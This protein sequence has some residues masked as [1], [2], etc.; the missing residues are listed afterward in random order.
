MVSNKIIAFSIHNACM[1]TALFYFT[2]RQSIREAGLC[3]SN[4]EKIKALDAKIKLNPDNNCYP[5]TVLPKQDRFFSKHVALYEGEPPID[6]ESCATQFVQKLREVLPSLPS[7]PEKQ[8]INAIVCL[9]TLP[10]RSGSLSHAF[11]IS[12]STK[13]NKIKSFLAEL[14]SSSDPVRST[15]GVDFRE[16]YFD[17]VKAFEN[18]LKIVFM[19][20]ALSSGAPYTHMQLIFLNRKDKEGHPKNICSPEPLLKKAPLTPVY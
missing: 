19:H 6:V 3:P 8:I 2:E 9:E 12:V 20:Q 1:A 13:N 7:S 14:V 16:I 10:T 15:E 5:E 17:T 4:L 18:A 11:P